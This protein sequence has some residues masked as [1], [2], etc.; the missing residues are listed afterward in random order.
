[1]YSRT[2]DVSLHEVIQV[3]QENY[4]RGSLYAKSAQK[5][6]FSKTC[7]SALMQLNTRQYDDRPL[8]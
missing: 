2:S 6:E 3:L 1:M 4:N 5:E 7:S 8:I